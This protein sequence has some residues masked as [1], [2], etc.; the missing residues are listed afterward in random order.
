MYNHTISALCAVI[1]AMVQSTYAL[2][3]N[4]SDFRSMTIP[5]EACEIF[6]SELSGSARSGRTGNAIYVCAD[7]G[8]TGAVTAMCPIPLS[9]IRASGT[10]SPKLAKFRTYFMDSD[11]PGS[12][13]RVYSTIEKKYIIGLSVPVD[14]VCGPFDSNLVANVSSFPTSATKNCSTV[15]TILARTFYRSSVHLSVAPTTSSRCAQFYGI[16]FP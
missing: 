4:S 8:S 12:E 6:G 10:G 3:Q 7:P 11:G 5:S 13:A 1:L 15:Q 9:N 14:L 2:A 16:D